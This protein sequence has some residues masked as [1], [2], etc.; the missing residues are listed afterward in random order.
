VK[1]AVALGKEVRKRPEKT[2]ADA[3]RAMYEQRRPQL[4]EPWVRPTKLKGLCASR[5]QDQYPGISN[6]LL[7]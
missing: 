4:D 7:Q 1:K 6:A 2:K 5:L 3:A